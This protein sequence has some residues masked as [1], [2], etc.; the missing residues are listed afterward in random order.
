MGLMASCEKR[1]KPTGMSSENNVVR[2]FPTQISS[3]FFL[4]FYTN[5]TMF[6]K[7]PLCLNHYNY[8]MIPFTNPKC[9][10]ES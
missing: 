3:L 5:F 10:T 4:E 6:K 7:K 1:I 8:Y 9:T 2:K